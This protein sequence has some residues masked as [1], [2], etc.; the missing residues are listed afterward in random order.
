M[1]V[2]HIVFILYTKIVFKRT[3]LVAHRGY[4]IHA[5]ENT[6]AAFMMAIDRGYK[7]IEFDVQL[8]KDGVP[9]IMHDTTI[10]RTTNGSG[11]LKDHT[12][13]ELKMLDAGSWFGTNYKDQTIPSLL[14]VL[15]LLRGKA[16]VHIELKKNQPTLP[17]KVAELLHSTG[18]LDDI[19]RSAVSRKLTKPK[20]I[21][22]SEDRSMLLVSMKLLPST[23]VH[24]IIVNKVTDEGLEWASAQGL[25]SYH[26][27]GNDI[28]P[29]LI[30]KAKKL[31]L[32][33][34]AWWWTR[35]EQD[36]RKIKGARYA[37]VDAPH[38]HRQRSRL[39]FL[40]SKNNTQDQKF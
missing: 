22:S 19:N 17:Q 7:D 36:V 9:M 20:I 10:D 16:Y 24:E 27:D 5:P 26:P 21:I 8:T 2:L 32:H 37:F 30:K 31:N 35:D 38:Q 23:V 11:A 33:I 15:K 18:W 14:E 13:A 1:L 25:Y 12:Y 40:R 6:H 28:T 29:E 39:P 4:S 34:G 3:T